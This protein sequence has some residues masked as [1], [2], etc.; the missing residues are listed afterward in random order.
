MKIF[1][2]TGL[3][4]HRYVAVGLGVRAHYVHVQHAERVDGAEDHGVRPERREADDPTVAATI[5][6]DEAAAPTLLVLAA[7]TSAALPVDVVATDCRILRRHP[8]GHGETPHRF[9]GNRI[10]TSRRLWVRSL[11]GVPCG[12]VDFGHSIRYAIRY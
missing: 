7:A 6:R 9:R 10:Y 5:R 2:L 3:E 1:Q 11:H 4:S 8:D 12:R